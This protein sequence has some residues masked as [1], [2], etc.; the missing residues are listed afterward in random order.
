MHMV[1]LLPRY[2]ILYFWFRKYIFTTWFKGFV[3]TEFQLTSKF[4]FEPILL[5]PFIAKNRKEKNEAWN[6]FNRMV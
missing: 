2:V 1:S 6:G 3:W 5:H 4:K